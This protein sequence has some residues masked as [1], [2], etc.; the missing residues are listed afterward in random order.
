MNFG[1]R[2]IIAV[3]M[4]FSAALPAYAGGGLGALIEVGKNQAAMQKALDKE[5][6]AYE[7][8]KKGMEKGKIKKGDSGDLIRKRYGEP[9]IALS[10]KIYAE[11]WLYKPGWASHFDGIKIYLF[12]DSDKKLCAIKA[13]NRGGK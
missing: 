2:I 13:V 4:L 3:F 5:T 8:V 11:K 10:D 6:K 1:S 9:V 7:A 12:F